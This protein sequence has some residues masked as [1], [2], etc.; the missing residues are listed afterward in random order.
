MATRRYLDV[1][2]RVVK[3][4]VTALQ[5]ILELRQLIR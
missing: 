3:I 2:E 5:A 4:V 1:A